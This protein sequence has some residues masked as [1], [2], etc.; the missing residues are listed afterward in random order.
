[1]SGIEV[2]EARLRDLFWSLVEVY[3]PSG[4]E[5]AVLAYLE[6]FLSEQGCPYGVQ[7]VDENR[8]NLLLGNPDAPLV[9]VGHV[10]TVDAWDLEDYGPAEAEE[11]WIVGLGTAD[12]KGGC[13]A[14][15]EAYLGLRAEGLG[16][17]VGVAL[18]VGE[19]EDGDGADAFLAEFRPGRALVAEPTDLVLCV[20]HYGYLEVQIAATGR[21]AHASVPQRGQNAAERLL[22]GLSALTRAPLFSGAG[23]EGPVLNIRHLETTNPGFAVPARAVAWVD[24]HVPPEIE[25]GSVREAVSAALA[26]A[27]GLEVEFVTEDPGYRLREDDPLVEVY[28]RV[29]RGGVGAFRSHSDANRFHRSGVPAF[30]LGPG[31][32]EFAHAE[33]ERIRWGQVVEAAALYRALGRAYGAACGRTGV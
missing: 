27:D 5:E 14:I 9:F 26:D 11:D 32:L 18:V 21:R 30:V 1:M 4:K 24:V 29:G 19:E 33:G 17:A 13:A 3:S 31:R 25:L 10:D 15:V 12:M 7:P 28:R 23:G 22:A 20:G 2:E 16:R 8:Y 6:E